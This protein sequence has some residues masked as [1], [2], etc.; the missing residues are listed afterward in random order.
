MKEFDLSV[1]IKFLLITIFTVITSLL[2]VE[3]VKRTSISRR[4]FGIKQEKNHKIKLD[5]RLQNDLRY[6][7][8]KT[9]NQNVE[10]FLKSLGIA[11]VI[12]IV[13]AIGLIFYI[14]N[15]SAVGC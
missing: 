14:I 9:S 15:C 13:L 10:E 8:L 3:L 1:S 11:I 6:N 12:A 7:S 5:E 4:L 2:S